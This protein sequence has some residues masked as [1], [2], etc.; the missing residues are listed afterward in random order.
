MDIAKPF[1]NKKETYNIIGAAMEVHSKLG[2][3]Y[4]EAVYQEAM[5]IELTSRNIPYVR[6]KRIEIYYKNIKLKKE[7]IADFICYEDI[8]VE[9]KALSEFTGAHQS[10]LL[11]YLT[12]TKKKIGLLINFGA[13]SLEYK[14]M[15]K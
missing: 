7:Y 6:E 8:I 4:L 1:Y 15:V 2:H 3:G 13:E 9:L 10:Q 14:R 5:E 12:A 11:N